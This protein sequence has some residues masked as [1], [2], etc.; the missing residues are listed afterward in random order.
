[1]DISPTMLGHCTRLVPGV[2]SLHLLDG[3]GRSDLPDAC[4]RLVFSYAVVLHIDRLSVYEAA[5]GEMCRLLCPGG[6]LVLQLNCEDYALR[7]DG[8]LGRTENFEDLS[9]HYAPGADEPV[10]HRH[11]T[12][13]GVYIGRERLVRRLARGG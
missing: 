6:R 13:S 5:I 12:W 10:L 4:A 9:L 3:N 7:R 8:A 2:H 1:I 11:S